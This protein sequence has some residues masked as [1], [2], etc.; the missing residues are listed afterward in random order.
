[1]PIQTV[2]FQ[3]TIRRSC[4]VHGRGYWSGQPIQLTFLP[5]EPDTGIRFVRTDLPGQ[6]H[7]KAVSEN[8]I[9]MPLR[10]R[11]RQ[12]NAEV[13]M[14]EHV[15]AALYGLRIDNCLVQCDTNEMPGLD[16]SAHA[17]TLALQQAEVER[18]HKARETHMLEESIRLGDHRQ[19]LV[20]FPADDH[21][22]HVEYRLDFGP[23]QS[24]PSGI[25]ACT[26]TPH[27][28]AEHISPART[29]ISSKDAE[30][31]QEKGLATHVT[32]RDLVVFGEE[33]PINNT[34][35]F[36]DEC[37]RHKLLDL[38]G[39][40]ALCGYDI[41]GRVIACRTGH[42]ANGRMAEKI[43]TTKQKINIAVKAA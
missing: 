13:D 16:G 15:M 29:F 41:C 20:A 38:I 35:R 34:L 39:D 36:P 37:A 22:L 33:G 4:H 17:I 8:R 32:D 2:R 27:T 18:Q 24:I 25:A 11:L 31:L 19:W 6:P 5:A 7:I 42:A 3:N 40:L 14:V 23:N 30:A 21:R 28:F 26:L 1:M 12:N 10:T 43:R 9:E